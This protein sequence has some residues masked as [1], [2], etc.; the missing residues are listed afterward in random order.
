MVLYVLGDDAYFMQG[1]RAYFSQNN[2]TVYTFDAYCKNVINQCS[3][4]TQKDLLLIA[5]EDYALMR[6]LFNALDLQNKSFLFIFDIQSN[7]LNSLRCG[8][9]SKKLPVRIL[10]DGICYYKVARHS[11]DKIAMTEKEISLVKILLEQEN[12][13]QIA[14]DLR[15]SDKAIYARKVALLKKMGLRE[16]NARGLLLCESLTAWRDD[17]CGL[18]AEMA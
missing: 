9:L 1:V 5:I 8:Y 18:Q 6:R 14:S 16:L 15:V 3:R 12:T 17:P 2:I 4:L 10:F 7:Y 11:L 13:L